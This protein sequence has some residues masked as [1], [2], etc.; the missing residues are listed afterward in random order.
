MA[1]HLSQRRSPSLKITYKA[2]WSTLLFP[3]APSLPPDPVSDPSPPHS[4]YQSQLSILMG[5]V[6]PL[7]PKRGYSLLNPLHL[8]FPLSE[9]LPLDSRLTFRSWLPY[10]PL[11]S[12]LWPPCWKWPP[13][14]CPCPLVF[15]PCLLFLLW[16]IYL[17]HS[18]R[19]SLS[20]FPSLPWAFSGSWAENGLLFPWLSI[21]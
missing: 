1:S 20:F 8:L 19:P 4:F 6:S 14:P 17:W 16:F 2:L 15:H 9:M 5:S 13:C 18:F 10:Q 3:P 12:L 21:F 7:V 11:E